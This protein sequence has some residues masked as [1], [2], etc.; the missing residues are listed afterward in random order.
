MRLS[1]RNVFLETYKVDR[2]A[3]IGYRIDND[4]KGEATFTFCLGVLGKAL[5]VEVYANNW[6]FEN[7]S[8]KRKVICFP[9][10]DEKETI[11]RK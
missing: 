6:Y 10:Y 7:I 5:N 9:K 8:N 11:K 4:K 2:Q 3:M 1:F